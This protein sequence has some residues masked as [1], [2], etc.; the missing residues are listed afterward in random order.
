MTFF[1]LFPLG[2]LIPSAMLVFM[3][4]VVSVVA[5]IY[6]TPVWHFFLS[7]AK[8]IIDGIR[9]NPD[10]KRFRA[11]H[12]RLAKFSDDRFAFH[13]FDGL[14]LSAMVLLGLYSA[15]ELVGLTIDVVSSGPVV[16]VDTRVENLLLA[17]RTIPLTKLFIWLTSLGDWQILILWAFA[18]S[19]VL[20]MWK[21]REYLFGFWVTLGGAEAVTF[22]GKV[23]LHRLRPEGIAS[24]VEHSFSYP[25]GHAT[26]AVA[27]YGFVVYL[28]WRYTKLRKIRLGV[29]FPV[30]L[31]I[32]TIGFSRLY[33]GVHYL[34]DVMAGYLVGFLWL[35]I[36]VSATEWRMMNQ[37]R[38]KT[39]VNSKRR[40]LLILFASF[41]IA[42]GYAIGTFP[43]I[44]P[45][46]NVPT[47]T[48]QVSDPLTPFNDGTLPAYTEKVTGTLSEP[49]SFIVVAKSDQQLIDSFKQSGWLLADPVTL[50]SLIQSE[51][52]IFLNRSY[53]T[54]PMT[55]MFWNNHV[56]DFGFEKPTDANS[57]RERH[58]A[59]FWKTDF[60]TNDG[61]SIYVGVAS[62]DSG[63]K[64]GI[65]HRIEPDVDTERDLLLK[66]LTS[67]DVV[68]GELTIPFVDPVLGKNLS[69]DAFFTDGKL[70][71]V[72]LK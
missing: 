39:P 31:V 2:G 35:V 64:W 36:G 51:S 38:L 43:S 45:L 23:I 46:Q 65:T 12:P 57:A 24:V 62:F 21:K 19:L 37:Q 7:L 18:I 60:V 5:L 28:I 66:D 59:R 11:K 55:P 4:L 10:I 54:E 44:L 50:V 34:S 15:S 1:D 33:L 30:L 71:E 9:A 8:S 29:L 69:G 61:Q 52:D 41:F 67:A 13:R 47:Q 40:G 49:L 14:P 27:F 26:I 63:F 32:V 20:W 56:H 25:S 3:A 58:H 22:L 6:A 17:F 72:W 68:V 48:I 42:V 70:N 53:Q 16:G